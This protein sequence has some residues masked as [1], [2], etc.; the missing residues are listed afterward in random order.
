MDPTCALQTTAIGRQ[1]ENTNCTKLKQQ[2]RHAPLERC[3]KL[4]QHV[5]GGQQTVVKLG[6]CAT[7][8][9]RNRCTC[10]V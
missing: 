2:L 7:N 1:R 9:S 10:S 6:L 3:L 5:L 4:G 8:R